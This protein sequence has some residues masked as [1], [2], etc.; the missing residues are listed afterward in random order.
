M[1][2]RD[3]PRPNL[4]KN[5]LSYEPFMGE[6]KGDRG[7]GRGMSEQVGDDGINDL[8]LPRSSIF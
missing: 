7:K 1:A 3:Q 4:R 6:E 2:E 5:S 8:A